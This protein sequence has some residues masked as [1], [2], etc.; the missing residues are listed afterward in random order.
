MLAVSV[1]ALLSSTS[2][3]TSDK[4]VV[5]VTIFPLFDIVRIIGGERI[6]PVLI[7]PPGASPHVF[8]ANPTTIRKVSE[9]I[10]VFAIG[11]SIDNWVATLADDAKVVE[12]TQYVTLLPPDEDD[13]HDEDLDFEDEFNPHYWLSTENAIAMALQVK[14]EL[15]GLDPD[16]SYYYETQFQDFE[17]RMINLNL[18]LKARTDEL[19]TRKIATFHNAWTY[20]A[21]EYNLE[22]VATFE[23]FPGQLPSPQYLAEF[24][25]IITRE[26]IAAVFAE[27]QFSDSQLRSIQADTGVTIG[28]LDPL[29]GV[30]GRNSFE[31]LMIYNISEIVKYLG[32]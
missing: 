8:E 14:E 25:S 4:P 24:Q 29:G 28:V 18:E 7:L 30:E 11:G 15:S 9:S 21:R 31:E 6:E 26:Q 12:T 32:N 27:P 5:S 2:K 16:N 22:V 10:V 17:E 23:E 1:A 20:F 3:Q 19:P 13:D